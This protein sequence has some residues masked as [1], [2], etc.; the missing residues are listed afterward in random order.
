[1]CSVKNA[2]GPVVGCTR[3]ILMVLG[4]AIAHVKLSG[5]VAAAATLPLSFT[6]AMAAPRTIKIG[7]VQPTTGPLAFFTEHIPF[8]LDQV[9]KTYGG[10]IDINGTKH[11]Y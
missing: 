8:V 5:S 11:P 2:S 1:M 3:P 7:L 10:G 4:A 6:W 9:K